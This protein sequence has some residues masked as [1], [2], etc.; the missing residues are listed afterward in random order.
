MIHDEE[1]DNLLNK[2]DLVNDPD[3]DYP[4]QDDLELNHV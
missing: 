1:I 3:Y 4:Q 2:N